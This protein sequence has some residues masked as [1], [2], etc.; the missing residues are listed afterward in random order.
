M[1]LAAL[2]RR[3]A[4]AACRMRRRPRA[5]ICDGRATS[6]RGPSAPRSKR[7]RRQEAKQQAPRNGARGDEP[8]GN[9]TLE[10]QNKQ[11]NGPTGND[12]PA[13]VGARRRLRARACVRVHRWAGAWGAGAAESAVLAP[14]RSPVFTTIPRAHATLLHL[15]RSAASAGAAVES[16][17]DTHHGAARASVRV[18][19]RVCARASVCVRVRALAR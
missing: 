8:Q 16:C 5:A 17:I 11:T 15:M 18:R 9:A 7:T 12:A 2:A 6:Q 10:P 4:P 1:G 14:G 13:H 19:A 3:A